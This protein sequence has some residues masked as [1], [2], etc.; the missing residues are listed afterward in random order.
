MRGAQKAT[1]GQQRV[2]VTVF[3]AVSLNKVFTQ[4][5][6]QFEAANSNADLRLNFGGS[7]DLAQQ[8]VNG[9]P[10]DVFASANEAQMNVVQKVGKVAGTAEPFVTNVL[11]IVVPPGNPKNIHFFADLAKPGVTEVVCAPQVP[12]G[13]ATE[14]IEKDMRVRGASGLAA[15]I[16][17]A[18]AVELGLHTGA[19][20]WF[21]VKATEV[22]LYPSARQAG[23]Q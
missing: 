21:V 9:A 19:Q 7:S 3:A 1:S 22:A 8:I 14:K 13:A 11:T 23:Q 2:P 10:A 17:P 4:L 6:P 5:E 18:A 20:V 16:T 12:C 15:D